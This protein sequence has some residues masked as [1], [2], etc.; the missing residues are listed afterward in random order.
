MKTSTILYAAGAT[1]VGLLAFGIYRAR[2]VTDQGTA[3]DRL[4]GE[5]A[6]T[7][8]TEQLGDATGVVGGSSSAGVTSP[9]PARN[10]TTVNI[11]GALKGAVSTKPSGPV[12]GVKT[13]PSTNLAAILPSS[14]KTSVSNLGT[15]TGN[16]MLDALCANPSLLATVPSAQRA[17][18]EAAMRKRGCFPAPSPTAPVPVS[19]WTAQLGGASHMAAT[20]MRLGL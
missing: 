10:A 9:T 14:T 2:R 11:L 7:D 5:G 16:A 19:N 1:A 4:F 8:L 13:A 20:L 15:S 3:N 12:S 6:S 17:E 18:W